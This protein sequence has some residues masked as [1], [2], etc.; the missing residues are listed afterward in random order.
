MGVEGVAS[1]HAL[2]AEVDPELDASVGEP[3]VGSAHSARVPELLGEV[4][5]EGGTVLPGH[6]GVEL[7]GSI[8]DVDVDPGLGHRSLEALH[9][10]V[11]PRARHIAPDLDLHTAVNHPTYATLPETRLGAPAAGR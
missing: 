6:A 4:L 1:P 5:L 2:P 8:D 11:A 9:A 10:H 3:G 7:E